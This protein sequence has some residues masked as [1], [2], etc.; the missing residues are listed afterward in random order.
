M[1]Y[2]D[3]KNV[4]QLVAL[5]RAYGIRQVVLCPGSRDVPLVQAFSACGDFECYSVTDERSA[6]FFAIGLA[7]QGRQAVAVCCTSG[8]ALL[9][10]HP[11]VAEAFYRKVPLVVV[12]ADRPAAWIGQMDGQTL[13]QPGAFGGLVKKAVDLPE[14][15]C[16]EDEW[17]VNRL[18]NEALLELDHHGFGPVHI[19]VPLSEPL[20]RFETEKLPAVRRIVRHT[21]SANG[22]AE[23]ILKQEMGTHTRCMVVAGQLSREE[24]VVVS[25]C[26]SGCGVP[27]LAEVLGNVAPDSGAVRHFDEVLYAADEGTLEALRPDLVITLGGHIVSKRLKQF[28]RRT[29]PLAHWH[30]AP[31]GQPADLFCAQT[32]VVEASVE[33]FCRAWIR[34]RAASLSEEYVCQWREACARLTRPGMVY[35]E[36]YAVARILEALPVQSVLHLGNSSVVRLA[37]LFPL[38]EGTEVQCNRGMNGIEGSVSAAVGYAAADDRLN[39]LLVGDLSFFYDMN[40][41]WNGHVRSNLRIV[42]LNYGG[43]AIFHALPGLDMQGDTCRFVTAS[44]GATARGWAESCGFTYLRATDTISLLAALDDLFDA[45][46]SCPVLLEV[47]TEAETDAAALRDYYHGIKGGWK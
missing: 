42:V 34:M 47:F 3:K 10:L 11:A 21:L 2:T 8:S 6:G 15:R 32:I 26:F 19:N 33:D 30:V 38:P 13:P 5:L 46:A 37:E 25:S 29:R 22:L 1:G 31:D 45:E 41:L 17:Y 27:W 9:N 40:G 24:A 35:S 18:V 44:H 23:E 28:L 4:L 12:S 16:G 43:G 39:V 20:F 14:V 7:L 36:L